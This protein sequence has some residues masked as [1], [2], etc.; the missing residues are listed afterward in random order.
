MSFNK[1]PFNATFFVFLILSVLYAAGN[2]IWWTIN[3]PVIPMWISAVHFIDIFREGNLFHNAPL[4]TWVM[5][6]M[7][8]TFGNGSYD[9]QIIFVNYVFFL[10]PLY[11]VY[12]IGVEL[13]D[14]ETGN[15]AMI[16]FALVPAVRAS[17]LSYNSGNNV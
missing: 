1:K 4:L 8:L 10:I 15:I 16:L 13:K 5:R 3:T 6:L 14:K 2:F 11:F 7:F 9:L 17:G 12:K